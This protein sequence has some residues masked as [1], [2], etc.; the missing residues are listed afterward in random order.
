M[1]LSFDIDE[2]EKKSIL[3]QS[4]KEGKGWS[5]SFIYYL[6]NLKDIY[7]LLYDN[8]GI[9][10]ISQLLSLC[11][12]KN[13]KTEN[14]KEWNGRY[15]LEFVNAL[16]N[17]NF[18]DSNNIPQQGKIFE[19]NINEPLTNHDKKVFADIYETYFRFKEFHN[20]FG[21]FSNSKISPIIYAYMDGSRFFNRFV[22][23]EKKTIFCIE[24]NHQDMM[25]FWDVYTKWGT[26]LH[27]LNK[28][29]LS[30]LDISSINDELKN[31]YL[32]YFCLPIP[33]NF[34]ILDYFSNVMHLNYVY[35][36]D[37]ERELIYEYRFSIESIKER[38]ILETNKRCNEYRLQRTSE[39]FVDDNNSK[40][41]L[42]YS[43]N[44][45]MSHLIKL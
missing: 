30:S 22:C 14:G 37:L 32:L 2:M 35:I 28:C 16:K 39:I 17:F 11:K 5:Y 43:E 40:S 18:I 23:A 38:L 15:L 34:S 3:P 7:V 31:A 4:E 42:P 44:A 36:P 13:V 10:N 8:N 9:I 20:L 33:D 26:Y 27:I 12:E 6:R 1:R 19:S 29:S 45:F 25:R 21:G 41:L 24:N